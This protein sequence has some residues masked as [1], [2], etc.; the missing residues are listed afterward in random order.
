MGQGNDRG[1]QYRSAISATSEDQL[2]LAKSSMQA[3]QKALGRE[4]TTEITSDVTFYF[5]EDYHQQ[6]LAKP[7]ARQY[8]SAM[9]TG[10]SLPPFDEWAPSGVDAAAHAPKLSDDFWQK[11]GPTP[12]CTIGVP[13]APIEWP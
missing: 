4:I 11:H 8:C 1:T 13:N 3:Y 6:Y 10:V 9:P 12:T 2:A 7:G 5:A